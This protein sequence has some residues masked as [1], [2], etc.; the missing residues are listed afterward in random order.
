MQNSLAVPI[1][2]RSNLC[3]TSGDS[4][5]SSIPIK[6]P[7]EYQTCINPPPNKT[8]YDIDEE[9]CYYSSSYTAGEQQ[10]C[11]TAPTVT[12]L[13]KCRSP[14]QSIGADAINFVLGVAKCVNGDH[15]TATS[16]SSNA[17]HLDY[18]LKDSRCSGYI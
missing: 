17:N 9:S 6:W 12:K 7:D 5:S 4:I 1:M 15:S 3:E 11:K 2:R 14:V 18:K 8:V 13:K 16:R 10:N